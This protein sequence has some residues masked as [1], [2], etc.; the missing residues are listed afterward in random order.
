[1]CQAV[2][3]H[4]EEY[5]LG[6]DDLPFPQWMLAYVRSAL[7]LAD[8]R[9]SLP[10]LVSKTGIVHEHGTKGARYTMNCHRGSCNAYGREYQRQ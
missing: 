10:P 4:I 1:M 9:E 6:P 7:V 5:D 2:Q 8:D 3:E